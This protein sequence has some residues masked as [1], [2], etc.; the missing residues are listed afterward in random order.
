IEARIAIPLLHIADA[1]GAAIAARGLRRVGLLAT[2][3]TMEQ[4]FYRDRLTERFG[5]DVIVPDEADRARIHDVIYQELCLGRIEDRSRDGYRRIA[6]SLADRGAQGLI[7]GC[8]EIMMLLGQAD[9]DLPVFDTTA[10]HA[11]AAVDRALA[12]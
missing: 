12:G 10:L 4:A 9:V 3:F 7:F 6:G 8:T 5:L 1:T 2:R 11:L